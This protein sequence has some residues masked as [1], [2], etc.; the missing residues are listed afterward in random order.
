MRAFGEARAGATGLEIYH[1]EYR[2]SGSETPVEEYFTPI[3]PT[4]EGL[5]QPRLRALAQQALVY[6]TTPRGVARR[7]TRGASSALSATGSP[8]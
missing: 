7:N 1:P 3:Y 4:T 8:R 2:M 6:W 5:N